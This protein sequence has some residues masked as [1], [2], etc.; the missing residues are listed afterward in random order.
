MSD[1]DVMPT[2]ERGSF[3]FSLRDL[4]TVGFRHKQVAL[5]CFF[6]FLLG[7]VLA[8]IFLPA[9][10]SAT[11]K[12]LVD[13]ERQDPVVS[14]EQQS[15]V[16]VRNDVTEE[17]LNS[18]IELLQSGDVLRQVVTSCGL[19]RHKSL[20]EYVFGPMTPE[21]KLAK[22]TEKL[23]SDLQI[24]LVKKSDLISVTYSNHDPQLAARVLKA[25]GDAYIRKHVE[26]HSPP[27]QV[28]FFDGE[29][30]RYKKDLGDAEEQLKA[31]AQQP[32]GVAP[33]MNRDITLQ[34][35][36]EF[37]SA[38]QQT[39]AEMADSEERIHTLEKQSGTTPERLTTSMREQDDATVL[40]GLKNTLMT[41]DL[42][43]TELLTKYQPTYPLVQ[44]VDKEIADTSASIAREEAKPIKEETT[45][46]NPTY[47]WINEELAKAKADYSGLRARAAA[48]QAIVDKYDAETRDLEKKGLLEQDLL[49]TVKTNEENY[50][51]Y[52]R[53]REQARMTEALDRT[54]I[55]NVAVA[56]QPVAPVLPS[57]S[58][59]LIMLLGIVLAVMATL[60]VV[61][62]REYMDPSFRT[63]AEVSAELN[64]PVLASVP[65][66]FEDYRG[67]GTDGKYSASM[68]LTSTV[69]ERSGN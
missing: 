51:L 50:L 66:R 23:Q 17:E 19:D 5:R 59:A 65:Q 4:V 52:Q 36:S 64:I 14:P 38:L 16:M 26:V 1:R 28:Q 8:A 42:K 2:H 30:D 18:E 56:E 10:Y 61:F 9:Q 62:I 7:A 12:F 39:R 15:S 34:K 40:Q 33:Q 69:V 58:P 43:R 48:Q 49:R 44:E 47:A 13:R 27:G 3:S 41:L 55:V 24:E 68:P 25:L 29:T 32:G 35:L 45:D 6:G 11:T 60:G 20:R 53:K 31:F 46:R 22:A 67:N 37:R 63:P 21:K 54:R 57:I